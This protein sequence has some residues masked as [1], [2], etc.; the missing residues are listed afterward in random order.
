MIECDILITKDFEL[1]CIHDLWLSDVYDVKE[2][3]PDC[4]STHDGRT[5]CFCFD[6]TLAEIRNL[7]V[8]QRYSPSRSYSGSFPQIP[9]EIQRS[10]GSYTQSAIYKQSVRPNSEDIN[11]IF[12][13]KKIKSARDAEDVDY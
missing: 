11:S 4:E 3:F 5:D 1:I 13:K 7:T 12:K 6:L 8:K 2:K 9:V 10:T